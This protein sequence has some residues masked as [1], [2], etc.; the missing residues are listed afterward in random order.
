[1]WVGLAK[2]DLAD[3]RG[4]ASPRAPLRLARLRAIMMNCIAMTASMLC[5]ALCMN[6]AARCML[7]SHVAR[8]MLHDARRT[9][10]VVFAYLLEPSCT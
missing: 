8:C 10:Y 7:R 9:S 2:T 1:M 3:R 5:M 4:R 6:H